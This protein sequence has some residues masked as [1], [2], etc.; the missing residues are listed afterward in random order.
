MQGATVNDEEQLKRNVA[1]A[2][3]E[4]EERKN[5]FFAVRMELYAAE[6]KLVEAREMKRKA[7][8][9]LYSYKRTHTDERFSDKVDKLRM[10]EEYKGNMP[11]LLKQLAHEKPIPYR[12]VGE[13]DTIDAWPETM[14]SKR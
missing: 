11:K 4:I 9:A 12:M 10:I 14:L 8:E 6:T 2:E 7:D 5:K 1:S 3:K 13:L